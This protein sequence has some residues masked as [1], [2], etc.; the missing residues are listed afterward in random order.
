M[1]VRSQDKEML[2]NVIMVEVGNGG[3]TVH[4]TAN[5]QVYI[6]G[7]Y[8]NETKGFK[9]LDMLQE[10]LVKGDKLFNMPQDSEV[11]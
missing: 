4:G 2:L 9:V 1:W 10:A 7:N 3:L 8:S 11:K 6:L 5:Q